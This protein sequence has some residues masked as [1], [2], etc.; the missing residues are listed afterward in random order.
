MMARRAEPRSAA[1]RKVDTLAK[2]EAI[3]QD[4]WIASA[5]LSATGLPVAHLVPLSLAWIDNRV[6]LA[7]QASS[8][9]AH[10]V[11]EQR[12]ARLALGPTRDVVIIDAVL[13]RFVDV[14]DAP[15]E[16]AGRYANQADWD[17]RSEGD[18]YIYLLLRPERIQAWREENELRGRT[19][20]R[21][22]VWLI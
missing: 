9:T 14:K 7:L 6:V 18:G 17:P 4:V 2:L 1:V 13:D 12:R 19:L 20:M 22:S 15:A 11:L 10:N 3:G 8:Q 21:N 5:S 16:L